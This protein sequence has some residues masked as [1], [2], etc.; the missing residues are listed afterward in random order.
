VPPP[1]RQHRRRPHLLR[2]RKL[3][4]RPP[5]QRVAPHSVRTGMHPLQQAPSIITDNT[6]TMYKTDATI[7]VE[8][9]AHTDKAG[10]E[11][12]PVHHTA[13]SPHPRRY[14]TSDP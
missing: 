9:A 3:A 10:F 8:V 4:G 1:H 6:A 7:A 2:Q 14:S 5:I 13:R 11:T 12:H